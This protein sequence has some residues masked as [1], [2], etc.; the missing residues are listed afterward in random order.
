[1]KKRKYNH[2]VVMKK[3]RKLFK[4]LQGITIEETSSE[5]GKETFLAIIEG[6]KNSAYEGKKYKVQIKVNEKYPYEKP[7]VKFVTD[8]EHPKVIKETKEITTYM[9]QSWE[10][11]FCILKLLNEIEKSLAIPHLKHQVSEDVE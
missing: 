10:K 6:P 7:N 3:E 11:D 8:I 5:Y 9:L 1:M 2:D 4:Y